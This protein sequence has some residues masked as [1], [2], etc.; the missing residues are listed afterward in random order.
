MLGTLSYRTFSAY[1]TVSLIDAPLRLATFRVTFLK[2]ESCSSYLGLMKDLASQWS[3]RPDRER[4]KEG[5][6]MLFMILSLIFVMVFPTLA[7]AMTGYTATYAAF[8][9]DDD[10]NYAR[11]ATFH[12]VVYEIHDSQYRVYNITSIV[13]YYS[14]TGGESRL[15]HSV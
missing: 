12:P 1:L 2:D 7:G 6:V 4:I 14:K 8:I 11:F 3:N 5:L 13:P 9:K 15:K 10:G